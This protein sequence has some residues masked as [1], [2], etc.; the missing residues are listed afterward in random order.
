MVA[1][2][3]TYSPVEPELVCLFS[4][5]E[6]YSILPKQLERRRAYLTLT[7]LPVITLELPITGAFPSSILRLY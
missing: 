3:G 2:G 1:M 4:T 6:P 7:E 5:G